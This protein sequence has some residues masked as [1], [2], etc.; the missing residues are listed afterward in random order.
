LESIVEIRECRV[1]LSD[2]DVTNIHGDSPFGKCG[3]VT[4]TGITATGTVLF[5]EKILHKTGIPQ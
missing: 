4:A 3:D 1:G 5:A 2:Y